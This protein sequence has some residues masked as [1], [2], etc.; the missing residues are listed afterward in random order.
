MAK[1]VQVA[2]TQ[3]EDLAV[4]YQRKWRQRYR[5]GCYMTELVLCEN[6]RPDRNR[7]YCTMFCFQEV[8]GL[9]SEDRR[10]DLGMGFG[11]DVLDPNELEGVLLHH[12]NLG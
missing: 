4:L 2:H 1:A 6:R 12:P 7:S 9:W 11:M 5:K 8:S 3:L 10:R